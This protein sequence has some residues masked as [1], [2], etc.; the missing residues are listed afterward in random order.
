MGIAEV[1][2]GD[3]LLETTWVRKRL[4]R[5]C[6]SVAILRCHPWD[7][8]EQIDREVTFRTSQRP[9]S[10][11]LILNIGVVSI[12][13]LRAPYLYVATRFLSEAPTLA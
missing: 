7:T 4:A 8:H 11:T 3:A 12:H 5:L 9:T 10:Y 6:A 13:C 2:G 1:L